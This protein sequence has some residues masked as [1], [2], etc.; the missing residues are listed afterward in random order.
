MSPTDQI[1]MTMAGA[2]TRLL[3]ASQ[4]PALTE[5]ASR[6]RRVGLRPFDLAIACE[7]FFVRD[8]SKAMFE[9]KRNILARRQKI[10]LRASVLP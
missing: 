1:A 8:V 4:P 9:T 6:A 10:L 3:K 7:G 2:K 5:N